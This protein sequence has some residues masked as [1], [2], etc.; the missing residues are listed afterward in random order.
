MPE[1]IP[2]PTPPPVFASQPGAAGGWVVRPDI[3]NPIDFSGLFGNT[4]PVELELG[5]GD[6]SFIVR[7]AAEHPECN[8][9][10]IERLL[11]RLRKIDRKARMQGL[12]NL[13][14]MR[15][16]AGYL[17]ERMLAPGS[18]SAIH[19]YFPDPWPKRRHWKHRLIQNAFAPFAHE[20]LAIGGTVYL[21]TDHTG[22]F[23]Q[24]LAVFATASG[25]EPI[26]AP[27]TL[28]ANQTDFEREFNAQGI[29]T[30]VA[31]YRKTSASGPCIPAH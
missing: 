3:L 27:A 23:D 6:G 5:A 29:P 2:V 22:Y 31:T 19:V 8:F 4:N 21:R 28:L 20:A 16:E 17:L 26:S 18:L 7:H 12:T 14:G 9:L 25:F 24:M 11:G 30:Q 10:A 15:I 1:S 13:R